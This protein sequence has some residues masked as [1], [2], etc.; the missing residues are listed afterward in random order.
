MKI[1]VVVMVVTNTCQSARIP[2]RRPSTPIPPPPPPP[3]VE[4]VDQP[5][6]AVGRPVLEP[7]II[8]LNAVETMTPASR[9]TFSDS[10]EPAPTQAADGGS[11]AF[12]RLLAADD[13]SPAT[14][15][16]APDAPDAPVDIVVPEPMGSELISAEVIESEPIDTDAD[17]PYSNPYAELAPEGVPVDTKPAS[18]PNPYAE[19][20]PNFPDSFT[21]GDDVE[22][23]DWQ[24]MME[25]WSPVEDDP[26]PSAFS[27][28]T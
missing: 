10:I 4:V 20:A 2:T 22:P 8:D 1:S 9:S 25:A 5:A 11:A 14:D 13:G 12:A 16:V 27:R 15:R 28:Y 6:A 7:V 18:T 3:V 19:L 24:S 23:G 26:P 21:P 17:R